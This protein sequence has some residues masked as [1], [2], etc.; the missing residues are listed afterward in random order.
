MYMSVIPPLGRAPTIRGGFFP[1][2]SNRDYRWTRVVS[3]LLAREAPFFQVFYF[4]VICFVIVHSISSSRSY[5]HVASFS[6]MN[7][8]GYVP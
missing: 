1:P 8:K 3:V 6:E 7:D 5:I 2:P 4:G